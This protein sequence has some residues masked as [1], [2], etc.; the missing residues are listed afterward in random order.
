MAMRLILVSA[1]VFAMLAA[2]AAP[3]FA[4]PREARDVVRG[5]EAR[6]NEVRTLRATFLE[7]YSEG[8]RLVRVES[9]T[10]LFSRPG[11]M[12]WEY[13][14]P[15]EKL[16]L[17]DGKNVWFYVPADRTASRA[18]LK[19]SADWQTPFAMLTRGARFTRFCGEV[20]L[21]T[22][23]QAIPGAAATSPGNHVLRCLPRSDEAGFREALLEVDAA[24]TLVRVLVREAGGVE[25]EFRFA[26]WERDVPIPG[27]LFH[28]APPVGVAIVEAAEIT[29]PR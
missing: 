11:R 22:G 13:E 21:V 8:R 12:R 17:V 16:F 28:F 19:E 2:A 6:Y 25:L 5:I 29:G 4:G 3:A 1:L 15:E 20:A 10:V 26:N 24:Y 18:D 7:R 23:D 9:G 14:S 27:Y